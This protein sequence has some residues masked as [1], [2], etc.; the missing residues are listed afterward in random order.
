[1]KK[2]VFVALV[3]VLLSVLTG[4][5]N[6]NI[7]VKTTATTIS[8]LETTKLY[9]EIFVGL[10]KKV[11]KYTF[12]QC[13]QYVKDKGYVGTIEEPTATKSGIITIEDKNGF[14]LTIDCA[15]GSNDVETL[16]LLSYATNDGNYS[17]S[18]SDFY[19]FGDIKYQTYDMG[20]EKKALYVKSIDEITEFLFRSA[21]K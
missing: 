8:E 6:N 13:K 1:M 12:A 5:G 18:V 14:I 4:C 15:I 3:I 9:D 19:G 2:V 17:A 21:I 10:S 11:G 7:A 20:R 16:C